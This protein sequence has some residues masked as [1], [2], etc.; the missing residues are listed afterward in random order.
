MLSMHLKFSRLF[1]CVLSGEFL[2]TP[3]STKG[4]DSVYKNFVIDYIYVHI[5][6]FVY[7]YVLMSIPK[8]MSTH[9]IQL[10][11]NLEWIF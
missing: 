5:H 9:L 3:G 8:I 11:V 4:M 6:V 7:I 2:H 10:M 1:D